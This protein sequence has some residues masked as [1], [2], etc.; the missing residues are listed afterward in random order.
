MSNC[1]PKKRECFLCDGTGRYKQPNDEEA[2]DKAFDAHDSKAYFINTKECRE[3]AL[4][5]V[6]YTEIV[7]PACGGSGHCSD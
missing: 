5:E 4:E 1:T 7:C 2:F 6:G 3:T